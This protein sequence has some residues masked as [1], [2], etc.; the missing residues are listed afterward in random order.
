[1]WMTIHIL[2]KLLPTTSLF[3]KIP[4]YLQNVVLI[5]YLGQ[6]IITFHGVCMTVKVT[7][8]NLHIMLNCDR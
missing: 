3:P 2:S 8:V 5:I 1:M 7:D 6:G 4:I